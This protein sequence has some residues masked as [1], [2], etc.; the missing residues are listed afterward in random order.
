MKIINSKSLKYSLVISISLIAYFLVLSLIN[1]HTSPL[2]SIFNSVIIGLGIYKAICSIK[3]EK[4][5][6][7]E[8]QDG[9]Q[10]GIFTGF[11]AT[12]IHASFFTIYITKFNVN[13]PKE[14]LAFATNSEI[15][16]THAVFKTEYMSI[17]T[18]FIDYEM[19]AIIG[20]F[21]FLIIII[22]GFATSYIITFVIM[23]AMGQKKV[24]Q[25]NGRLLNI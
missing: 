15:N 24:S 20:I 11:M 5:K 1:K 4:G 3:L 12:F 6:R 19:P 17:L 21:G 7:F 16:N 18:S 14:L 2:F 25:S 23:N 13:F 10:I 9:F 22:L 8:Y